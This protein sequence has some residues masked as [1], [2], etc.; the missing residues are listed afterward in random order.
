MGDGPKI[1][2]RLKILIVDDFASV[3]QA[4]KECLVK[5]GFRE[6]SEAENGIE[7]MNKLRAEG[8]VSEP[9]ELIFSDINMPKCDGIELLTQIREMTE[10]KNTPII[11]VSTENER[12][13][14][15]ECIAAG[16]TNY[17]IK[18]FSSNTIKEKIYTSLLKK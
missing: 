17:V 8:S 9:Y 10:Y 11:M 3:R 4:L 16:A 2:P 5:I 15:L 1:N 7:A 18:P 12:N 6:I 13:I 14:V